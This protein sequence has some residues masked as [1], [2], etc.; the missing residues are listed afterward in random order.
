MIYV[1]G[2]SATQSYVVTT[3]MADLIGIDHETFVRDTLWVNLFNPPGDPSKYIDM[4]DRASTPDDAIVLIGKDVAKLYGMETLG[5][6]AVA[7]RHGGMGSTVV[8]FPNPFG[9]NRWWNKRD[10]VLRATE[11][12]QQIWSEHR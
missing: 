10:N 6:L 2:A 4:V 3:K 1:I 5:P 7:R 8:G 9:P 11:T 12:L